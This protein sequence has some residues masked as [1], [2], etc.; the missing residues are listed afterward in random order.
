[1]M[2]A[3]PMA[4]MHFGVAGPALTRWANLCRT[5]GA[6]DSFA[7]GAR[8]EPGSPSADKGLVI[9]IVDSVAPYT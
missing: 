3:A 7:S 6:R 8:K 1:M 2:R 5:Y 4:L 9:F